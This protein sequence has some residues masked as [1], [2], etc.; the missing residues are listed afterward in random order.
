VGDDVPTAWGVGSP[1]QGGVAMLPVQRLWGS[2][3][4]RLQDPAARDVDDS[5]VEVGAD[6]P[7]KSNA[8]CQSVDEVNVSGC[9]RR[10]ARNQDR[11]CSVW[12]SFLLA[13]SSFYSVVPYL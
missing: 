9:R 8:K 7:G 4:V 13:N 6:C 2:I 11:I 3:R 1:S 5:N 12:S 10:V